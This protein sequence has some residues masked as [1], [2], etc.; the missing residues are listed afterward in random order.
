MLAVYLALCSSYIRFTVCDVLDL[1][2]ESQSD[3]ALELIRPAD[4]DVDLSAALDRLDNEINLRLPWSAFVTEMAI[5]VRDDN[6]VEDIIVRGLCLDTSYVS[7]VGYKWNI[8]IF[9]IV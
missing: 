8:T 6:G 5:A 3:Y 2:F 1:N 7:D 9:I 4:L